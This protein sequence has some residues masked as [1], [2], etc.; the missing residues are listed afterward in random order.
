MNILLYSSLSLCF[1]SLIYPSY[2]FLWGSLFGDYESRALT[3]NQ[4]QNLTY[5]KSSYR[6]PW[7]F[8]R[9]DNNLYNKKQ[10]EQKAIAKLF[11]RVATLSKC[12]QSVA[13]GINRELHGRLIEDLNENEQ[14]TLH[15][16]VA[17]ALTNCHLCEHGR[18]GR[19]S[20]SFDIK[21][22]NP[23]EMSDTDFSIY[24]QFLLGVE[25]TFIS[26][27]G[28]ERW[29][30]SVEQLVSTMFEE[31]QTTH[32]E[33]EKLKDLSKE[34]V[35]LQR[36]VKWQIQRSGQAQE[37]KLRELNKM[38]QDGKTELERVISAISQTETAAQGISDAVNS[39]HALLMDMRMQSRA[40]MD[41]WQP[42]LDA[43]Q[44]VS[45]RPNL[46]NSFNTFLAY[47][48]WGVGSLPASTS[49]QIRDS[50]NVDICY[51]I[52]C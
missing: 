18:G 8:W 19:S 43:V 42:A 50:S 28:H 25:D 22:N 11:E 9:N 39:Q 14:R 13:D 31:L 23:D 47:F 37:I 51:C 40:L 26:Q 32:S 48:F 30:R 35:T 38:A 4:S 6:L 41:T 20:D 46:R 44:A 24:T 27:L 33:L 49:L 16:R 29:Q 7:R 2:A 12:K 15:T 21:Y 45:T 3:I 52:R 36:K 1:F 10:N 17:L 34:G 5:Y